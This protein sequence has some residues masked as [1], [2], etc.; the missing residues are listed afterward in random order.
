MQELCEKE[1]TEA[2]RPHLYR[3]EIYRDYYGW[4]G[5]PRDVPQK[6][7][8]STSV[9]LKRLEEDGLVEF[10]PPKKCLILYSKAYCKF[11]MEE[12]QKKKSYY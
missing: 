1:G 2:G 6:Y 11:I 10:M 4:K 8:V 9:S 12:Y 3:E 7:R 5:Y